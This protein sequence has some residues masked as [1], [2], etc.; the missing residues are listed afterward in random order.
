MAETGDGQMSVIAVKP[1]SL[2][3]YSYAYPNFL[4]LTYSLVSIESSASNQLNIYPGE[5]VTDPIRIRYMFFDGS[6]AGYDDLAVLYRDYMI[7]N[8]QLDGVNDKKGVPVMANAIGA[9]DDI[10]SILGYPT[11]VIKPLTNYNQIMELAAGLSQSVQNGDLVIGY[12]GW[13]EGGIKTGYIKNAKMEGKLG[14]GAE[15]SQMLSDLQG[16]GVTLMPVVEQQYCYDA[17]WYQGFN[18]LNDTI[19]FITR[20][21][22]YKPEYNIA[23][24]YLDDDGLMPYII[25]PDL[26]EKNALSFTSS[27]SQYNLNALSVG[28]MASE[29][30]SDF[31][32]KQ[33]LSE[34]DT[35]GYFQNTMNEYRQAGFMLGG[36]GA[37][38]YTLYY[39]D[40]A[41][42][43]PVSAS[44]HPIIE[45]SVPFLQIVL[46]GSVSYTM[47]ALNTQ[48]DPDEYVLKAIET[49]SGVYLIT[50]PRTASRLR[51]PSM[52]G[53]MPLPVKVSMTLGCG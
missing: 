50:L 53:S 43:L 1:D 7:A 19:R 46:S 24:Y 49:G 27:L 29:L 28:N 47:P 13:L 9:I 3:N 4:L 31:N 44:N 34:N 45:K 2:E 33:V 48:A 18:Q 21:T 15:F 20:D 39:L 30:Y 25:R 41:Y 11:K 10:R 38:A 26:V 22:G 32:A 42:G 35:I 14:S 17:K 23:N 6:D 12:T 37:N 5:A 40:Y 36:Y 51:I 52:M 8:G 16:K